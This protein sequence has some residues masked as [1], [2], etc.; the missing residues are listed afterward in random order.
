MENIC[1]HVEKY[2]F[3][4]LNFFVL[5]SL[6]ASLTHIYKASFICLVEDPLL[7]YEQFF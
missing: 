7:S 3:H 1:K 2:D 5:F 6:F 4:G